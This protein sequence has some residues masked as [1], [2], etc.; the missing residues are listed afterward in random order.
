MKKILSL[1]VLFSLFLS[2]TSCSIIDNLL[3]SFGN[4]PQSG[5]I[6]GNDPSS[7]DK[8]PSNDAPSEK[9]PS[10]DDSSEKDPS[11]GD[12]PDVILSNSKLNGVN[13]SEFTIVYSSS[14]PDYTLRAARYIRSEIQART[15]IYLTISTDYLAPKAHEIVVGETNRAISEKLEHESKSSE[16]SILAD[17][18]SVA[19]EADYFII[20]AAAYFFIDSYVPANDFDASIPEQTTTHTPIVKEAKNFII[21]IGDGMGVYQTRLF[22][23]LTNNRDFSDGEDIFYGYYLPYLAYSRTD[24]LSGTTDSAAGATALATGYKTQNRYV[25]IDINH[26][27]LQ[28]ITE[29]AASLGKSTAVMSTT[30]ASNATPACFSAHAL[31]RNNEADIEADQAAMAESLGTIFYCGNNRMN[32]SGITLIENNIVNI[33]NK[34]DN[35]E[36]G[37]FLMYEEGHI[38]KY[39]AQNLMSNTF[40]CVIRFNQIIAIFMEYAYYNPETVVIITADHETGDLKPNSNGEYEFGTTDHT[41]D[42]VPVFV[43]GYGMEI[44]DGKIVENVQ[45]PKTIAAFMGVDD[46]GDQT[47]YPSLKE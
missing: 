18:G 44:F 3:N 29:L 31:D 23:A 7:S 9:D 1:L 8:E 43:H 36:D 41:S 21:L 14:S 28:S 39:A 34:L 40:D 12:S 27:E 13:L 32:K 2:L 33:L 46:F 4:V 10:N 37:F 25:G 20:A 35:D 6:S 30:S 17:N 22:E 45:I 19:L 26:N 47:A 15:G 42:N 11:S 24:S 38:D 5:D 16:F